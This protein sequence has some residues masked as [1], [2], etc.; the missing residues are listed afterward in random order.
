MRVAEVKPGM[1][2]YG[3]SVFAGTKI[4]KFDVEVISILR[5]FSPRHDVVLIRC[6]GQNLEHTGAIQGM[7]GSPI[8]L[9]DDRGRSRMIG[10][11]AYGFPLAK[12][13]IA[14][15][16]PIEYMLEMPPEAQ[17]R[18]T[19]TAK[20]LTSPAKARAQGRTTWSLRDSVMLPGM[21]EPPAGF[22][23]AS[24]HALAPNPALAG[25]TQDVAQ[26]RPLITPLMASGVTGS[27]LSDLAP[28][29]RAYGFQALQ[30]GGAGGSSPH[31]SAAKIEPG[32]VLV[33]PLVTGDV[34]LVATGTCTEVLGDRV[35]AFGHPF[36]G[37]GPVSLPMGA[38]RINGIVATLTNSFKLGSMTALRGTLHSDQATGVAGMLGAAPAMLPVELR[39]TYADGSQ[40]E[41]Y[42]FQELQHPKLT[43]LITGMA[44][45]AVLTGE[46]ELPQ[47]HTI[48]YDVTVEF[49]NGQ[50]VRI[51]NSGVN[52]QPAELFLEIG[53]PLIAAADNP[54]ER[55]MASKIHG[56]IKIT[57]EARDAQILSINVPKLKYRPGETVSASLTYRPFRAG[58]AVLPITLELPTDLADGVYRLVIS[59]WQKY[60]Q[61][62]Q[63]FQPFRFTAENVDEVF[64]VLHDLESIRH[65]AVYARL[66]R[67]P[68][69]V[70]VG[71]T[72][73]P[74][75]PS[76][77][78]NVLLGAGRSNITPFVSSTVKAIPTQ[79]LMNGSAEFAITI[80]RETRVEPGGKAPK[81]E[82]GIAP[83]KTEPSKSKTAP[84]DTGIE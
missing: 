13:P 72:A 25:A 78:R 59:D 55:V 46:R 19:V 69:G 44:T 71:R 3:L 47:Y 51:N 65:N 53:T 5:N 54:F 79:L 28:L 4:E 48:D 82:P 6:H 2:G 22:P 45:L 15:I 41:V 74:R 76:S 67:K 70:A 56:A 12:D 68:D 61:D 10:A 27:T 36:N 24:R 50:S 8:F 30:A 35:F 66:V 9:T 20:G 62:E 1:T 57:P 83:A 77:R 84:A 17:A 11:F 18:S 60:L 23:L 39:V 58:E 64:A 16:Q 80:D 42:H 34:D 49:A 43:P 73:M 75:L 33:A 29:L 37:E 63:Q 32:S 81:P 26:L 31:D 7:S 21:S 52:L 14:G 38:G 40:D